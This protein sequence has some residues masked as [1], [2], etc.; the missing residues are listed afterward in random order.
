M[1]KDKIVFNTVIHAVKNMN[2]KNRTEQNRTE[3]DRKFI[4]LLCE[5]II[6]YIHS[7]TSINLVEINESWFLLL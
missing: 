5:Y 1:E 6:I 4:H 2:M 7:V 3:C